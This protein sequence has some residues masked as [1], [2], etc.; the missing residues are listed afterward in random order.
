M[1]VQ[2]Q[3]KLIW[4]LCLVFLFFLLINDSVIA[5]E[6]STSPDIPNAD[7]DQIRAVRSEEALITFSEFPN[8]TY[9]TD[10]YA[11]HGI[12]F[13]GDNP[14]IT[15]DSANPTSPVLSGSPKFEGNIEG[16]FV[17]PIDGTTP[18]AVPWFSLDSGYY[19]KEESTRLEWFDLVGNKLGE[20]YN[21]N[22]GIETTLIEEGHIAS[23]RISMRT[24]DP[25]GFAI[26]NLNY[27]SSASPTEELI[28]YIQINTP[29][30]SYNV[31]NTISFEAVVKNATGSCSYSWDLDGDG[32]KDDSSSRI[33]SYSYSQADEVK[34]SVSVADSAGQTG[35]GILYIGIEKQPVPGEPESEN[36]PNP[37]IGQAVDPIHTS[38]PFVFN[39]SRKTNGFIMLVHGMNNSA[40]SMSGVAGDIISRLYADSKGRPNI[41]SWDW[42]SMA[43]PSKLMP[44][45]GAANL[46]PEFLEDIIFIKP[47]GHAQGLF[48]SIYILDQILEGNISTTAPIH[49]IGHSAGGFAA[50]TAA[51]LLGTTVDQVSTLDTPLPTF[52]AT[53]SK[54]L[55]LGGKID[56]YISSLFGYVGFDLPLIPWRTHRQRASGGNGSEIDRHSYAKTWYPR[57]DTIDSHEGFW[58]SPIMGNSFSLFL[59]K[60]GEMEYLEDKESEDTS[61]YFKSESLRGFSI[62]GS[63]S[64]SGGMYTITESANAGIY[65]AISIPTGARSLTFR[66]KFLSQGVGDF[67][68]VHL[69]DDT[70]LYMAPPVSS[71]TDEYC[72]A[73]VGLESVQRRSGELIFKLISRGGANAVLAIDS[74]EL[75]YSTYPMERLLIAGGDY[76]GDGK[77]DIPI[78]RPKIGLWAVKGVTRSYFG[79]PLDLPVSGDYSGDGRT[80][81]AIF[82]ETSGLWAVKGVTRAYFGG[83]EDLAVPGDYNGDGRV[84]CAIFRP[85]SG[86]WA[87]KRVTR[88]YYGQYG[89]MHV[90]GIY[91]TEN[92]T[93][94]AIFRPMSGLWAI[95]NG[96][97]YYFGSYEDMP[98]PADYDGDGLDELGIFRPSSGLWAI[99]GVTR[100]YF[101]AYGDIPL[102]VDLNGDGIAEPAIFRGTS[103]LWA[104]KGVTRCY[105]GSNGDLPLS[106]SSS[107]SK[108]QVTPTP[109]PN[110]ANTCT[111]E[112]MRTPIPQSNPTPIQPGPQTTPTPQEISYPNSE[113]VWHHGQTGTYIEW[114]PTRFNGKISA[115]LLWYTGDE[116]TWYESV[117]S[118]SS[119]M[120]NDGSFTRSDPIP[121]S[122]GTGNNYVLLI[123][124]ENFGYEIYSERFTIEY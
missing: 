80:D 118:F 34:V 66:Y 107:G 23:W 51:N 103:G 85:S 116:W 30:S 12:I 78:F 18:I 113:T 60:A 32:Q 9:I 117:G 39:D 110:P 105:F 58:L 21:S 11:D 27:N 88:S 69:G 19:D 65:Q 124:E 114:D 53:A 42:S 45:V 104:V 87:V 1:K 5:T 35:E 26:D 41:C 123:S 4:I 111:P 63:V 121:S 2:K 8:G 59:P 28:V 10:Q 67:F 112:P 20:M 33:C 13:G 89:D 95:S 81:M 25:G 100:C 106:G 50:I 7:L 102:P 86:L 37:I 82:R 56:A 55:L 40:S 101:G 38:Q 24:S 90:P 52:I 73:T 49:I 94:I 75:N 91:N 68:S 115:Y 15:S 57:S 71:N 99:R 62:F 43:D 54:F 98:V 61:K 77:S 72:E 44:E 36:V 70:I 46:T 79:G 74:I 29:E 6:V 97:R 22:M 31:G 76:N 108:S 3:F 14:F 122:W 119:D 47:F 92:T 96:N 93:D 83:S 17:N 84:D 48:I 64:T 16:Y 109:I 120:E